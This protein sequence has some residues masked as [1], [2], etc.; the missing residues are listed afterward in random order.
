MTN[1]LAQSIL[2]HL[3]LLAVLIIALVGFDKLAENIGNRL[4]IT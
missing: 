3:L 1:I 4:L 2:P